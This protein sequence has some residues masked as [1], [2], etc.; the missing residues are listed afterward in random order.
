VIY[1]YINGNQPEVIIS[2]VFTG[3]GRF[4]KFLRKTD[5]RCYSFHKITPTRIYELCPL[6]YSKLT[7][8]GNQETITLL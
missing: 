8:T 2:G 3:N 5:I 1:I 4:F 7:Q 6:L